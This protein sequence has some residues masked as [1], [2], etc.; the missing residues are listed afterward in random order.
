[1]TEPCAAIVAEAAPALHASALFAPEPARSRLMVLYALDC[2]LGEAT[3]ASRETLIRQMR[4]QW[5]RDV[6]E[7][8]L[9]GGEAP[10]HVV[11]TP[12][13]ELLAS[14][15]FAAVDLARLRRI[16]LELVAARELELDL[17]L[18]EEKLDS[19]A[20]MRFTA[21]TFLASALLGG[22]LTN[23]AWNA[24]RALAIAHEFATLA[25]RVSVGL[26][27]LVAFSNSGHLA[28]IGR[29]RLPES[30]GS[31]L[32]LRALLGLGAARDARRLR[33]A[34]GKSATPAF[35]PLRLAERRL[36]MVRRTPDAVLGKLDNVD[37]PFDGLGFLWSAVSGRW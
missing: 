4:V 29:G 16:V 21:R 37:R 9:D 18:P 28:Q 11:A 22:A 6:L 34:E 23:A 20:A 15:A 2:A 1:M 35:L 33:R 13:G 36:E 31:Y 8:L 7:A 10:A 14:G 19:C 17:P 27:P 3:Y 24:G 32:G 26:P 5:W 12:F 25:P 30:M